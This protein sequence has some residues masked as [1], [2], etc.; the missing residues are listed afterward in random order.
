[1]REVFHITHSSFRKLF[2]QMFEPLCRFLTYYTTDQMIVEEVVQEVF[3]K[4]W[5]ERNVLRIESV[6][7]YLYTSARNRM[8]NYLRDEKRRNMLLEQ[9]VQH[10]MEK[11]RGEEC[12]DI[13]EFTQRVQSAIDTLPD[14][15]RQIF[16]LSKK[17]KLTYKQIADGLQYRS[18]P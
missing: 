13:N 18:K 8:L 3:I 15:C 9:W 2:D 14:K 11:R 5:E 12:F 4:L 10:E 6:K 17:E 1:M 7:T 16:N